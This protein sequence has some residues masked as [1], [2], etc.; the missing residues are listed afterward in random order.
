MDL[1]FAATAMM[2]WVMSSLPIGIALGTAI[3]RT[4]EYNEAI[5]RADIGTSWQTPI[6]LPRPA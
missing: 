5:E 2:V 1:Q 4:T 6:G 3:R